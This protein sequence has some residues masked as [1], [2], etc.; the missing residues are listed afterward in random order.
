MGHK[1]SGALEKSLNFSK[2][3]PLEKKRRGFGHIIVDVLEH[4]D[5]IK[6]AV[7]HFQIRSNGSSLQAS[8]ERDLSGRS[9]GLEGAAMRTFS[10]GVGVFCVPFVRFPDGVK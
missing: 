7:D 1:H 10:E 5:D 3:C 8:T 2:L 6:T 4:S 9:S